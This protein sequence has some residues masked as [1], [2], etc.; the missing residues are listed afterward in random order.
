MMAVLEDLKQN[1]VSEEGCNNYSANE[2]RDCSALNK[3][4]DCANGE[5]IHREAVC[6]PYHFTKYRVESYGKIETDST[7]SKVQ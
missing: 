1:G 5:D 6:S 7:K 3:C 4:K 2:Q